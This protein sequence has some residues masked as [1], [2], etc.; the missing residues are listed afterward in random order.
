MPI[1]RFCLNSFSPL[2]NDFSKTTLTETVHFGDAGEGMVE[3][4]SN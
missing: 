3:V 2:M 4:E 1:V